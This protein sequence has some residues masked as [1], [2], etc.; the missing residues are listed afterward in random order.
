MHLSSE[1]YTRGTSTV[2]L[3]GTVSRVD[4]AVGTITIGDL[5]VDYTAL[6]ASGQGQPAAGQTVAVIGVQS[7][8]NAALVASSLKT[9]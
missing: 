8:P 7:S 6:L 3:I 5:K 1:L 2:A 9:L 4:S